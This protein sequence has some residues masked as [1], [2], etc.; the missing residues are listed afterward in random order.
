MAETAPDTEIVGIID[1]DY[2]VD[3][4]WLKDLVPFFADQD[5][6]LVQ[7][8]QDHRDGKLSFMHAAMNSEYSGFFDIGMV[9]RNEVNAI[10][11]HGTMCLVRH[12]AL[13]TA[14]RWSSDTICED[15]DLGLS[16]M[17]L[18]WRAHY[19]T[20]RYGRGQL[21]QDYAAFR[22][23]RARWAGGAVQ[24]IKKHW[25]QFLPGARQLDHDQKREV[26]VGWL[27]WL[28]AETVAVAS[29]ILN[30]IWAP[31]VALQLVVIPDT[32]LT[33]PIL[34]AFLVSIVHL[35]SSYRLRV[36]VSY[37]EDVWRN[38]RVHVRSV[39]GCKCSPEGRYFRPQSLLPSNEER[40]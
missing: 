37:R 18:G 30:L 12:A 17:E 15:S 38:G 5:V 31:F 34:A 27:A 7:A 11:M 24:I 19:T 1:A 10:I 26:I 4:S 23:Q 33:L 16:V 32:L 14:G 29:A 6:G 2:V 36:A 9:E 8:P 39:D 22:T 13:V 21:P 40:R 20:R 25:R 3:S 35:L 28:G